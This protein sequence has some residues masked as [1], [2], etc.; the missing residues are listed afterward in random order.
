MEKSLFGLTS[1]NDFIVG[2]AGK[3]WKN[4]TQKFKLIRLLERSE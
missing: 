3:K 4:T 2:I 1:I